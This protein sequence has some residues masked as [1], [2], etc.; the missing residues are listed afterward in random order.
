MSNYSEVFHKCGDIFRDVNKL[1]FSDGSV[2]AVSGSNA[3]SIAKIW[4]KVYRSFSEAT[5]QN[6][7]LCGSGCFGRIVGFIPAVIIIQ[8]TLSNSI[9]ND[10]S[11]SFVSSNRLIARVVI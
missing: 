10:S 7:L 3:L 8:P 9:L 1:F 4:Y 6:F 5:P 11:E 2:S